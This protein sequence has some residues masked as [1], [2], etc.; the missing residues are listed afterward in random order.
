MPRQARLD[1]GRE[2][3]KALCRMY[4]T[5]ARDDPM[6]GVVAFWKKHYGMLASQEELPSVVGEIQCL[7]GDVMVAPAQ[8]LDG[9]MLIPCTRPRVGDRTTIGLQLGHDR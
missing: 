3:T 2:L 7:D 1:D 9:S 5:S 6:S 4:A 8:S